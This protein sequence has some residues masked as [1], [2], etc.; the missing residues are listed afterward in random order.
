MKASLLDR[1]LLIRIGNPLGY[2]GALLDPSGRQRAKGEYFFLFL[3]IKDGWVV[4][5]VKVRLIFR[6]HLIIFNEH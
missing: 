3:P 1:R 2:V 4:L 5:E 6:L